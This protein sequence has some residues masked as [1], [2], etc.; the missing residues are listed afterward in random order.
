MDQESLPAKGTSLRGPASA[1]QKETKEA[2]SSQVEA[3]VLRARGGGGRGGD[4]G[5]QG[6]DSKERQCKSGEDHC[7][8]WLDTLCRCCYQ[9]IGSPQVLTSK[10]A[11]S[12]KPQRPGSPGLTASHSNRLLEMQREEGMTF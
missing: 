11:A 9:L 12:S 4:G 2:M 1:M 8:V 10:P 3:T 6:G 7:D 5:G